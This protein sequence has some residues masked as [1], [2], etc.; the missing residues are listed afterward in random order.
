MGVAVQR[1]LVEALGQQGGQSL[2]LAFQELEIIG[3]EQ[4][5][6]LYSLEQDVEL[7]DG[8]EGRK[9]ARTARI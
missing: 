4:P 8:P 6:R 5:P 1:A 9:K 7:D 3:L 2:L